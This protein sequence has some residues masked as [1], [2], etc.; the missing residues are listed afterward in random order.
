MGMLDRRQGGK[1]GHK[2]SECRCVESSPQGGSLVI[3]R[4]ENVR[5]YHPRFLLSRVFLAS[6][7]SL[8][9]FWGLLL[10]VSWFGR[11]RH[12]GLDTQAPVKIEVFFFVGG[13]GKLT[14]SL[15]VVEH[16]LIPAIV[17]QECARL[18]K[19]GIRLV[20]SPARQR[21]GLTSP[22]RCSGILAHFCH[23]SL[24]G[25]FWKGGW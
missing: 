20:W 6:S 3:Y 23:L 5:P 19:D 1:V 2:T 14:L 12:P 17:R 4:A 15:W 21:H 9:R 8:C 22:K 18:R 25:F 11:V 13:A 7:Y 16:W 24:Y 10:W